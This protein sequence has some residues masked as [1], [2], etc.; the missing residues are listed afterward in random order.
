[1]REIKKGDS[2]LFPATVKESIWDSRGKTF[3]VERTVERTTKTLF[4][5]GGI[6][7][8]KKSMRQRTSD[9][10]GLICKP[11]VE[12]KCQQAEYEAC[13]KLKKAKVKLR[14]YLDV[15]ISRIDEMSHADIDKLIE[16]T[17]SWNE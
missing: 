9:Y 10:C 8:Y 2:V 17:K 6:Q 12:G 14:R 11:F 15:T 7:F 5:V 16:N 13:I 4:I 3:Y 1:M